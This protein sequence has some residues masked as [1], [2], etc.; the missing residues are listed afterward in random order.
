MRQAILEGA[1]QGAQGEID[2][3]RVSEVAQKPDELPSQFYDWLCDAYH[4]Y[5]PFDSEAPKN[6]FMINTTFVQ[7]SIS[8]VRQKL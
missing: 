3:T 7:Q 5:T 6:R 1:R 4:R 2:L 8:D